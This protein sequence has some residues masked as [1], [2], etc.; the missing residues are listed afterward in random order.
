MTQQFG[1]E[2]TFL[3]P[4]NLEKKAGIVSFNLNGIHS[5]DVAQVLDESHIAIRA[6]HHCTMPL[7]NFL[8][9]P[10]SAR[11]SF[12]IYNTNTDIDQLVVGLQKTQKLFKK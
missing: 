7:H 1:H 5:H 6:G 4:T 3:G 10:A 11:A 9:I 8:H 12:Y 2:I